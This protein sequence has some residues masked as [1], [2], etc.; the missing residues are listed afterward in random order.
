[1]KL[2]TE[3]FVHALTVTEHKAM[4]TALSRMALISVTDN[5]GDILYANVN[6]IETSQYSQEELVGQNHRILKSGTQLQ[7]M[8]EDLWETISA[9]RVWRGE[10]KNY[11]KNGSSFWM[12][13]SIVPV[14][15]ESGTPE[16]YISVGFLITERKEVEEALEKSNRLNYAILD[17]SA[18]LIIATD[19]SGKVLM[20]NHAAE[21]ALGYITAEIVGIKTPILWHDAEE[22]KLRAKQLSDQLH[23]AIEPGF[24]VFIRK[25]IIEGKESLEWTFIRKDGSQFPGNLTVTPLHNSESKVVGFLLIIEDIT[26]RHEIDRMKSEFISV[27]SH[28]LR[29]PLTSIR[30]SLGLIVGT[31]MKELPSKVRDL[32]TMAY[33]NNERLILLVDDTLNVEEMTSGKLHLDIKDE[34]LSLV[35]GH[36]VEINR[37]FGEKYKVRFNLAP[38]ELTMHA[39]IDSTR[40]VQVITNLLS[41]AAKFSPEGQKVDITA[42]AA[43]ST[44][45]ISVK[46]YG[47]GIPEEFR[48]R[49]F[50]RF[51]QA[52]SSS[53]RKKGGTGL[54][55]NI[56]KQMT[57]NM[58]GQIGFESEPG[59]GSTFWVEFPLAAPQEKTTAAA[60]RR[61]AHPS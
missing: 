3:E 42:I 13:M 50:T 18:Y 2:F 58:G 11:A 36:A 8:F 32:I 55:L 47:P 34:Q 37:I 49:I 21:S 7:K 46:D 24:D 56:A 15:G 23:E 28:E 16:R 22:M 51:S 30:G 44:V 4:F 27:I 33:K 17:S 54:G 57:E 52:D 10:I 9:G 12:D 45:R 6:F 48:T 26:V 1:M 19:R 5:A 61:D 41:N 25:P 59:Q 39:L 29:T 35:L 53:T 60:Q 43:G 14:K 31:M 38:V 20:F 40:F